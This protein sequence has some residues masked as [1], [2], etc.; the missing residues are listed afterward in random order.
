[1]YAH[2]TP[3]MRR[4]LREYAENRLVYDLGAGDCKLA[5]QVAKYARS[6]FAVDPRIPGSLH[7]DGNIVYIP[8]TFDKFM[9]GVEP[10][11]EVAL[12]SWPLNNDR[13]MRTLLPILAQ[14]ATVIY[15]G[16][17]TDGTACGTPDL[18]RYFARRTLLAE[19]PNRRNTML[20]LGPPCEPRQLTREEHAGLDDSAVHLYL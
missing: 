18:F 5:Q 15:I 20:V 9:D 17:N 8:W 1:M 4:V 12:V 16:C 13:A 19:I 14:A 2:L 3:K 10:P 6:V 11:Y 7:T